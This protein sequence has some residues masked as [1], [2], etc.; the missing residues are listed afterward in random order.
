MFRQ[1]ELLTRHCERA[2]KFLWSQTRTNVVSLND[3]VLFKMF[4][5]VQTN[6]S[7]V[8]I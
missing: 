2:V 4:K 3:A 7:H 6:E 8:D 1:Q 5:R